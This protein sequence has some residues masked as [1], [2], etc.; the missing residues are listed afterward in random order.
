M[1]LCDTQSNYPD[2]IDEMT[3]FSDVPLSKAEIMDMYNQLIA[4]GNFDEANEYMN[5]QE[6]IFTFSADYFNLIENRIHALQTYLL[7]KTKKHP[8][9]FSENQPTNV[10]VGCIWISL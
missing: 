1:V 9:V 7:T 4:Q 8:F 5:R 2:S 3:F 6:G 10:E